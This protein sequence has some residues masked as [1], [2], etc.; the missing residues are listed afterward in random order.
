MFLAGCYE[1]GVTYTTKFQDEIYRNEYVEGSARKMVACHEVCD[2]MY[3]PP[4]K[5]ECENDCDLLA[6]E[7]VQQDIISNRPVMPLVSDREICSTDT[8]LLKKDPRCKPECWFSP[9]DA[10]DSEAC[11]KWNPK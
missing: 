1:P 3:L 8:T 6:I 4:F 7:I 9:H 10:E 11:K 5:V 2:R